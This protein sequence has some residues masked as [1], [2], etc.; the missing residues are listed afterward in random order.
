MCQSFLVVVYSLWT[1]EIDYKTK[2]NSFDGFREELKHK[3]NTPNE[4]YDFCDS[5]RQLL[6]KSIECK[7]NNRFAFRWWLWYEINKFDYYSKF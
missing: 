2:K 5:C 3:F 4:E 6:Y 1:T 7:F